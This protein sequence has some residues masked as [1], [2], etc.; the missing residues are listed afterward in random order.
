MTRIVSRVARGGGMVYIPRTHLSP[1]VPHAVRALI[2][3]V[4]SIVDVARSGEAADGFPR[5]RNACVRAQ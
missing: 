5:P 1:R 3:F 4:P 2:L